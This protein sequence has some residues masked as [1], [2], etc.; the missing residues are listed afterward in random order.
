MP[1]HNTK[2]EAFAS[3]DLDSREQWLSGC[4]GP[5]C[6]DIHMKPPSSQ[7]TTESSQ[8]TTESSQESDPDGFDQLI[9]E[10]ELTVVSATKKCTIDIIVDHHDGSFGPTAD[11]R[12]VWTKDFGTEAEARKMWQTLTVSTDP[13]MCDPSGAI[14]TRMNE[15]FDSHAR[16]NPLRPYVVYYYLFEKIVDEAGDIVDYQGSSFFKG[17]QQSIIKKDKKPVECFYER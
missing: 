3:D 4:C 12:T 13:F 15:I 2:E 7:G 8:E 5:A 11:Q 16:L 14:R 6:W 1:T 10:L 9:A 17:L